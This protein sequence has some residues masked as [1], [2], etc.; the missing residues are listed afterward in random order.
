[1]I[2]QFEHRI[3]AHI[4]S[5]I[6]QDSEPDWE[7]ESSRMEQVY[8][9]AA[10]TIAATASGNSDGGLFFERHPQQSLPRL[11]DIHFNPDAPW[12]RNKAKAVYPMG[13]YLCDIE[14]MTTY[15]IERAPL[16]SR[17]WVSQERQLSRRIMHFS[18]SQVFW[19]CYGSRTCETYPNGIPREAL[20]YWYD[21]ATM[22]KRRLHEFSQQCDAYSNGIKIMPRLESGLDDRLYW[23]WCSFRVHYSRSALTRDSDKLVALCGIAKQVGGATGDELVAGLWKSRMIEELCWFILRFPNEN[24]PVEPTEWRAP[25]WS[26]AASNGYI[27]MSS[28]SKYHSGHKSRH[29]ETELIDLDIATKLSG[30]LTYASMR[31]RCRPML[32]TLIP[33]AENV[34]AT[35]EFNYHLVLMEDD[36]HLSDAK[37]GG[38]SMKIS[39][40]VHTD[41]P[42]VCEPQQIYIIVIQRCFHENHVDDDGNDDTQNTK[43]RKISGNSRGSVS[44]SD[45]E[46]KQGENDERDTSMLEGLLLQSRGNDSATFSRVGTFLVGLSRGDP[47]TIF[48][49]HLNAEERIITLV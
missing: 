25:T 19:E 35:Y 32:A 5:C 12:L 30:E 6:I 38:K 4:S 41:D 16:N 11:L 10:C 22:L 46:D 29:F 47:G 37:L 1:M 45:E 39:S 49:A 15:C 14:H 23:A 34:L 18:D 24:L 33:D 8:A 48:N 21:D 7:Y 40:H 20:P 42:T 43:E 31:I 27:W 2:N 36:V 3:P 44:N 17:A 13:T 28:V 26:W 9:H